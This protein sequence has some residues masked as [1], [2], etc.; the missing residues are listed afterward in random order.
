MKSERTPLGAA[1][2]SFT[3]GERRLIIEAIK[4]QWDQRV[5][6]GM[7]PFVEWGTVDACLTMEISSI[8]L[9]ED[10]HER[11]AYHRYKRLRGKVR[12]LARK[13]GITLAEGY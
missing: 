9:F 2:T 11:A 13:S 8:P 1:Y 6:M 5:H 3:K 10:E 7:L 12:S 4:F